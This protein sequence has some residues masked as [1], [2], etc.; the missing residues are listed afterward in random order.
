MF[1]TDFDILVII[2]PAKIAV[3]NVADLKSCLD[4]NLLGTM[5]NHRRAFTGK[6]VLK[7]CWYSKMAR[8][9][10]ATRGAIGK[11][12]AKCRVDD[13]SRGYFPEIRELAAKY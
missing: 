5:G 4:Y 3:P 6:R 12:T 8:E 9:I 13:S 10:P 1:D 7:R 2:D 11:A